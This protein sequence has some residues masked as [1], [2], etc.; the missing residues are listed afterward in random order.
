MCASISF[1]VST[2]VLL[3]SHIRYASCISA[4]NGSFSATA[5]SSVLR[6]SQ[7]LPT[8]SGL[9]AALECWA[10]WDA[11][12]TSSTNCP[13][14]T[15]T[16]S[17]TTWTSRVVSTLD[18]TFKLCDGHPRAI[19]TGGERTSIS[20]GEQSGTPYTTYTMVFPPSGIP[21]STERT[22]ITTTITA[23]ET[24]CASPVPTPKCS[25]GNDECKALFSSWTAGSFSRLRPPCTYAQPKNPCDDCE[26]YI[27][28]VKLIYFPVSMT[29]DF[30]GSCK[31]ETLRYR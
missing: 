6:G 9:Q 1:L 2:L 7:S 27:P 28:S 25:I 8:P 22:L 10:Q 14:T 23:M 11:F 5:S 24:S 29:G 4:A 20:L 12:S 26:I 16:D 13:K 21:V 19:A 15:I 17:P 31:F 18:K 30:C 3:T